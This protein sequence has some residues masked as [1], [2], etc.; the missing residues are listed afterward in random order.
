[1]N[2]NKLCRLFIGI[3]LV[4][5]LMLLSS[6]KVGPNYHAPVTKVPNTWGPQTPETPAQNSSVVVINQPTVAKWWN[7]FSD[8]KLDSLIDRA[9]Q[10]NLDLQLAEER[11]REA[12]AERGIVKADLYP[13]VNASASYQRSHNSGNIGVQTS[14]GT[15]IINGDLY[16]AGFDAAW[17]IDVFGRVRRGIEAADADIAAQIEDR[18][19]VLVTLLSEVA[20]TYIELRSFQRQVVIAEANLKAQ[21]ET[22]DL[23]RIRFNAGLVS[24]LDVARA[25]AQ[26][27]NTASQIPIF[28]TFIATS[29]HQLS[30]LLGKEPNALLAELTPD[31][32]IPPV[33]PTVPISLPSELL[34][35]RPD[36]RRAER[37]IAATT[38]RIGVAT[39]DLFPRFSLTGSAGL[40]TTKFSKFADSGSGTWSILPGVTIPI[41]F[42][43]IRSNIAVQNA[44]EQQAVTTYEQTILT[45]L[46][47]VADALVAFGNEQTRR[48]KLSAAVDSNQRAVDLADQLYQ[49]GLTDFLTVLQAQRDLY[50]TEDQLVQSN[51]AVSSN[52]VALY[53]ALGGGWEIEMESPP[54]EGK[55]GDR[56]IDLTQASSQQ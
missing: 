38:A 23:T 33:P 22:L 20:R 8:P 52:L 34:R 3:T 43:R 53:K 32:P 6:C 37:N 27:E 21:Q 13:T 44:R 5:S 30:V 46:Q 54:P 18:R 17:E 12:R 9:V 42:G 50:Q 7:T 16:Q 26:V 45:S 28:E 55:A 25:E 36:I 41:D 15:N 49:K 29:I 14:G 2:N 39:A 4:G 56:T 10:S 11:I 40:A 19:D 48:Q 51:R 31:E 35:R 24:D 1:M 47:E